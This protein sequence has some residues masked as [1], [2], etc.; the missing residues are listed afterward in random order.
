MADNLTGPPSPN[1]PGP[2]RFGRLAPSGEPDFMA[3]LDVQGLD[4][5]VL[6]A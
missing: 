1:R 4:V 5:Q 6:K 3:K 2:F